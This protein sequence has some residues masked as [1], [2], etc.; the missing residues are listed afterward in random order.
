MNGVHDI[1]GMDG[2]GPVR[3][4]HDEPVFHEPWEGRVFG[5]R[6]SGAGGL[7]SNTDA[8]RYQL[9]CLDPVAYL[10]SGYYER[11]LLRFESALI[12]AGVLTRDQ[13]EAAIG[14]FAANPD[15]PMPRRDDPAWADRIAAALG[16]G[17][18]VTRSL[19][20]KPRFAVGDRVMTRNLNPHGHTR[21]PRYARG[22]RGVI[23]GHHGAHVFAD[24]NA[25]G[26]GENPQHL[27]SVRISAR[28]LWGPDAEPNESIQ[29]DLWES[30]LE[31]DQSPS[32]FSV[33]KTGRTQTK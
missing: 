31:K 14:R 18:P 25:L 9:E 17:N 10:A 20:R 22:R 21:L 15:A 2:F 30:H 6:I 19:R 3:P 28:E 8:G 13:I 12:D 27:Y 16:V 1:G 23:V 24:S 7:R 4:Q 32:R 33:R 29:I 5:M 11:W 26:L